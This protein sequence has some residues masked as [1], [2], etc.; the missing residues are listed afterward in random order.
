MQRQKAERQ[1]HL[2]EEEQRRKEEEEARRKQL[3]ELYS[4]Q[5]HASEKSASQGK[6]ER[7][8]QKQ[9]GGASDVIIKEGFFM[10]MF[11]LWN[12]KILKATL[13]LDSG[14]D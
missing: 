4:K 11:S 3:S 2:K 8:R 14:K 12:C 9:V 10:I 5:K 13:K 6:K 7:A 1:R